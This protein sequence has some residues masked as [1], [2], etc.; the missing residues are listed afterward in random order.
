MRFKSLVCGACALALAGASTGS[1]LLTQ[2]A[3]ASPYATGTINVK[4]GSP[5]PGRAVKVT[6]DG[7]TPATEVTFLV[8]V[9][10]CPD[11]S[12]LHIPL[13][14]LGHAHANANGVASISPVLPKWFGA[15]SHHVFKAQG[16]NPKGFTIY[17][18]ANVTLG[19]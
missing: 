19:K 14:T 1:S 10:H 13:D 4:P 11:T 7:F 18:S 2:A 15:H 6:A 17:P 5:D 9:T 12:C 3:S 8:S 16:K